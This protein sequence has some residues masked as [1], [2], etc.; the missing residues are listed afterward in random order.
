MPVKA[1]RHVALPHLVVTVGN[2]IQR[3]ELVV[4]KGN[5]VNV[6]FYGFG[7]LVEVDQGVG[8][9]EQGFGMRRING[10]GIV[11]TINGTVVIFLFNVKNAQVVPGV[12]RKRV[13][14]E[15]LLIGFHPFFHTVQLVIGKGQFEQEG[16]V[17]GI[18]VLRG[19]QH[20]NTGGKLVVL[21]EVNGNV[22]Q[23]FL[24]F[25]KV[26]SRALPK[27]RMP[28]SVRLLPR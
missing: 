24:P 9:V 6:Q 20:F 4:T 21:I 17:I 10:Q 23:G 19:T 22:E 11:V 8:L 7:R 12:L 14:V 27:A 1:Q 2:V 18:V 13:D 3:Q 26:S 25:S 28:S 15:Q 5:V 16:I